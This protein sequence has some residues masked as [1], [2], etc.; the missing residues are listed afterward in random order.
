MDKQLEGYQKTGGKRG[1]AVSEYG[2]GASILHQE[3][4][5]SRTKP[6]SHWH[7]EQWQ[8]VVHE[9]NYRSISKCDYCWGS[10][11]WNMF[12][13]ASA[14]RDEGDAPGKNDKGLVTHDRKVR[15]D[16]F[17]FYMANWSEEP[18]LY[19]T[20]RR[21]TQRKQPVTAV[22][23]YSNADSV[24]LVLNGRTV[25]SAKPDEVRIARW[26]NVQLKNGDNVV[27]VSATINGKS[28][29]DRCVWHLDS[30]TER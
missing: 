17:Y 13:F 9:E 25:G 15:K 21:Y 27:E 8:S 29:K 19:I 14:W 20:S 30:Q 4:P 5:P 3:D 2:A 10:F 12:D 18:V 24:K 6:L 16:A 11:V 26:D 23:V 28:V 1:I 7:P 22:K